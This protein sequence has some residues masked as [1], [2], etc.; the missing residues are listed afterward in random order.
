ME[1]EICANN[2]KSTKSKKDFHG[3]QKN[4]IYFLYMIVAIL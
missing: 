2:T 1:N 4:F 3:S